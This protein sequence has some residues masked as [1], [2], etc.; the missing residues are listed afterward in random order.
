MKVA[1]LL[2]FVNHEHYLSSTP[3]L[4]GKA[5]SDKNEQGRHNGQ[6]GGEKAG[7]YRRNHDDS[8][9]CYNGIDCCG[10]LT[11]RAD[12]PG[13]TLPRFAA[14]DARWLCQLDDEQ[15]AV[16]N[17]ERLMYWQNWQVGVDIS[18]H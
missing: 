13:R 12:S 14:E 3:A 5:I 17:M 2:Y 6:I 15:T 10:E 9:G 8:V 16:E 4:A 11:Y 1:G 7:Q 18:D